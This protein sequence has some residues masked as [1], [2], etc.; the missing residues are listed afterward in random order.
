[1]RV[2][3]SYGCCI[4]EIRDRKQ[5]LYAWGLSGNEIALSFE[6]MSTIGLTAS[7]GPTPLR[8]EQGPSR[9]S[10]GIAHSGDEV[11]QSEDSIHPVR[12]NIA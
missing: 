10:S 7:S 2:R 11:L 4:W 6:L 1:M 5:T 3:G 9:E 12:S 8:P